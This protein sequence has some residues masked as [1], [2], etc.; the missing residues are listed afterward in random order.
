MVEKRFRQ[1]QWSGNVDTNDEWVPQAGNVA[2][3]C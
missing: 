2:T 3:L 1:M